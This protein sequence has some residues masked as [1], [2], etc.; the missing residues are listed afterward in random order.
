MV[1]FVVGNFIYLILMFW[2][3][4]LVWFLGIVKWFWKVLI[5]LLLLVLKIIGVFFGVVV[6]YCGMVM[7]VVDKSRVG[8]ENVDMILVM[9]YFV[10]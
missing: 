10:V 1:F 8:S 5:V 9:G 4:G 2:L 6:E 7:Y 3:F